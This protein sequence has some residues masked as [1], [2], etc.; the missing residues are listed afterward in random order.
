MT[1][2]KLYM[3]AY[4][5][6]KIDEKS[7]ATKGSTLIEDADIG[8]FEFGLTS[9]GEKFIGESQPIDSKLRLLF[10]K[11]NFVTCVETKH[12]KFVQIACRVYWTPKAIATETAK[13]KLSWRGGS[14]FFGDP[15]IFLFSDDFLDKLPENLWPLH[16]FDVNLLPV[17]DM[18]V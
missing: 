15:Q 4:L 12:G 2:C 3:P 1:D 18:I 6:W 9:F 17:L 5:Y 13:R 7:S 11:S 8:V 10:N 16:G 14:Q